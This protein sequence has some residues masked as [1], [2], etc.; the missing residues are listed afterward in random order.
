MADKAA[1]DVWARILNVLDEKLQFAFLEQA[2]SV[3]D[4]RLNGA[5]LTLI[6]GNDESYRFFSSELNQQRLIIVSRGIHP[7]QT[8]KIEK[9]E[10]TS[11]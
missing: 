11:I 1:H 9:V 5:E 10:A 7:L 8:F 2:R 3:V 4:V 6:V